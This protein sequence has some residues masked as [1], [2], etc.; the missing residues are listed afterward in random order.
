MTDAREMPPCWPTYLA[1]QADPAA[2]AQRF[3][4]SFR[5]GDTPASQDEGARLIL[6]GVKTATSDLLWTYEHDDSPPPFVGA[7]SVLADGAGRAVCIVETTEVQV[8]AFQEVDAQF[9]ADYG[10]WDG[11]L[12]AWR[13]HCWAYYTAQCAALGRTPDLKMPLVCERFRVVFRCD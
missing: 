12:T 5:I 11:T 1:Q 2:A 13:A 3:Y 7:L 10:E 9:A 8:V 4:G 6:A